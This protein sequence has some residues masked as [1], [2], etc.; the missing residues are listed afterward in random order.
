[1]QPGPE[2]RGQR[3]DRTNG[4][5]AP[6]AGVRAEYVDTPLPKGGGHRVH[7]RRMSAVAGGQL[8][9]DSRMPGGRSTRRRSTSVSS[10]RSSAGAGPRISRCGMGERN[11]ADSCTPPFR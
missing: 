7:V 3:A 4:P 9:A 5:D 8:V 6:R 11:D 10:A 1:M 2:R